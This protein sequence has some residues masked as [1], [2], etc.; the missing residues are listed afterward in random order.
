AFELLE[1]RAREPGSE[2][3]LDSEK[4]QVRRWNLRDPR[5]LAELIARINRI[6]QENPALHSDWSLELH[7]IANHELI[8]YS[9]RT[10][11]LSN[12]VLVVANL[13]P[14]HTRS[15]YV[16]LPLAQLGLEP[17]RPYQ[18]H[19]LLTGARYLWH[20]PRNYVALDPQRSPAHIFRLRRHVATE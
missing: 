13:D 17:S 1:D 15:G 8:C 2:E 14:H 3:Y 5:S 12:I 20:G 18:L 7:P 19:D 16:E 4:Y 9:K 6:R 11:D 10:E